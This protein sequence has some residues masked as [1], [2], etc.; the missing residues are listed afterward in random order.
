MSSRI[1]KLAFLLSQMDKIHLRN[2]AEI[3][4]VSEMTIRRDLNAD[5][6]HSLVLL[7]GYIVKD[8]HA[9]KPHHYQIFEHQDKNIAEK[10]KIGKIAARQV[11]DGDVVFFDCGST[12]PFIAS[13]I[14]KQIKFTAL[15]CSIN[16]FLVLQENPNCEL[17]LCGGHYSRDNSFVTPMTIQSELERVCTHKAF[18]STAGVHPQRGVTCFNFNEA[19]TKIRAINKTERAILVFDQSKLNNVEQAYIGELTDFETIITNQ[20]LPADFPKHPKV[21]VE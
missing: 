14:D 2:A 7:G 16:T 4:N 21:L 11:A 20:S 18:I 1:E 15:C 6:S 9:A 5:T 19:Q 10:L 3:L 8:P 17:I 12:I 13:Q